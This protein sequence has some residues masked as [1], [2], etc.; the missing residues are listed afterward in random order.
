[1]YTCYANHSNVYQ[2][3]NVNCDIICS[4]AILY[5]IY[6]IVLFIFSKYRFIV[7]LINTIMLNRIRLAIRREI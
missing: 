4:Y 5:I 6:V 1:M 7:K 3:T 2:E